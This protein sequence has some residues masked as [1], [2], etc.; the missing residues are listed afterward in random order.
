MYMYN[1]IMYVYDTCIYRWYSDEC[2]EK[3]KDGEPF[4]VDQES[5]PLKSV[6]SF[7]QRDC[8]ITV[9]NAG[10]ALELSSPRLYRSFHTPE[11][12]APLS[13]ERAHPIAGEEGEDPAIVENSDSDSVALGIENSP[14]S[15]SDTEVKNSRLNNV[16]FT[17]SSYTEELSPTV[18]VGDSDHLCVNDNHLSWSGHH[19]TCSNGSSPELERD[20]SLR[21][22]RRRRRE[23]EGRGESVRRRSSSE[24]SH[25]SSHISLS[26]V[27]SNEVVIC[28]TPPTLSSPGERRGE[29]EG[30]TSSCDLFH[31]SPGHYSENECVSES[32]RERE[33]VESGEEESERKEESIVVESSNSS[34]SSSVVPVASPHSPCS[35]EKKGKASPDNRLPGSTISSVSIPDTSVSKISISNISIPDVATPDVSVPNVTIPDFSIPDY[36]PVGDYSFGAFDDDVVCYPSTSLEQDPIDPAPLKLVTPVND[37]TV[38]MVPESIDAVESKAHSFKTPASC[39]VVL[40]TDDD[41]TPMPDFRSM[42]TPCLKGECAR[43]GVKAMPK[44]KMI[45]KLSEI[46]EHTHPLVGKLLHVPAYA[47]PYCSYCVLAL[48]LQR[49]A[50]T[51]CEM[52]NTKIIF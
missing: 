43:F 15:E 1:N 13:N 12:E 9:A 48:P 14:M 5:L 52:A 17:C 20:C 23:E 44:K 18:K 37:R 25:P 7:Q 36:S 32:E 40:Q 33:S 46:Y 3:N 49:P 29:R 6:S 34:R 4:P 28:K 39:G 47:V 21:R 24:W 10:R 16:D 41:I 42:R 31:P 26:S 38:T 11:L 22:R 19:T 8:T 35:I 27:D 45:A 50:K 2:S 51:D 30:S